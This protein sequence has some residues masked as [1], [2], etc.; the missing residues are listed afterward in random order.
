[1]NCE[2]CGA[3]EPEMISYKYFDF[4]KHYHICTNCNTDYDEPFPAWQYD[5]KGV[6]NG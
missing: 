5:Y 2:I 6:L 4:N 3:Y 1:M